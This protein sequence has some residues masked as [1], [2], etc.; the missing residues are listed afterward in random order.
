[1]VVN[2]LVQAKIN[3]MEGIVVFHHRKQETNDMLQ[4]WNNNINETLSKIEY[5]CHL[6]SRD[7]MVHNKK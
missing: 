2:K 6:I 5:T 3:R 1:M 4:S 7:V